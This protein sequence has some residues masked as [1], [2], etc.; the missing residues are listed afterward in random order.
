MT[1]IGQQLISSVRAH[2]AQNPDYV[3]SSHSDLSYG[4]CV[5][6]YDG[7]ASCLIGHALLDVGLI[8]LSF[9]VG[10]NNHLPIWE[11]LPLLGVTLDT[12]EDLWLRDVQNYQDLGTSW[13]ES[14]KLADKHC[15]ERVLVGGIG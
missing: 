7:S 15:L 11:L 1:V 10:E 6:I 2:A 4:A 5:Y 12:E 14:V 13:G 9:G 3:Y 8:D